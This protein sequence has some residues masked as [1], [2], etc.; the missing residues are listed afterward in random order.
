MNEPL[1]NP[2]SAHPVELERLRTQVLE[3]QGMVRLILLGLI[4]TTTGLC[5]FM[6]RQTKL[7][8]YQILAQ[9][10]TVASAEAAVAPALE[11]IPR[12]QRVGSLHPDYASNV[13]AHFGLPSLPATNV[14]R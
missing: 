10:A 4:I 6:Y 3:L 5:L 2:P 11:V 7:L 13:L 8:R 12:F 14:V 9:R 1:E